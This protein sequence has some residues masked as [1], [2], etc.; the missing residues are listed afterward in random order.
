LL[1]NH[2]HAAVR[3]RE[4]RGVQ[5]KAIEAAQR[6]RERDEQRHTEA[7][8]GLISER[9]VHDG[10]NARLGHA[11]F[12]DRGRDHVYAVDDASLDGAVKER[13]RCSVRARTRAAANAHGDRW[14]LER[15]GL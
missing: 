5:V 10:V 12:C 15:R 4:S 1:A 14:G 7:Q 13:G 6:D 9:A 2:Q 11:H 8:L 3:V